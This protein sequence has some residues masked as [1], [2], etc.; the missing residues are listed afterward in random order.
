MLRNICKGFTLIELLVVIA[1]IAILAAILF[2]VFSQA[3]EKARSIS[4][5]SNERQLAL[6]VRM[7]TEDY[8]EYMPIGDSGDAPYPRITW[9]ALVIPYVKNR[10]VYRC[11]SNP[12]AE[13]LHQVYGQFYPGDVAL[14]IHLSYAGNTWW[15][16]NLDWPLVGH[17]NGVTTAETDGA[18][19]GPAS[20]IM[21][22]E[23]RIFWPDLAG[24]ADLLH[25][26][27][28]DTS[29]HGQ[30]MHHQKFINFA[31]FDGHSK[32]QRLK[33]TFDGILQDPV[34]LDKDQWEWFPVPS[35]VADI[36]RSNFQQ[37]PMSEYY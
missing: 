8:D 35:W 34:D 12:W 22:G 25:V 16:Q 3:R 7:Y 27:D 21:L 18:P 23:S 31:Y 14:G 29:G 10:E 28:N 19:G 33:E 4:C 32:A 26:W 24:W 30:F 17:P 13:S 9:R 20:K 11:P 6:A 36:Y 37:Y 1:I 5:L 15:A 2:P